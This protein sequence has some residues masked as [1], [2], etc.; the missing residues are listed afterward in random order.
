VTALSD[1]G[2]DSPQGDARRSETQKDHL[3]SIPDMFP[4]LETPH[5]AQA[6]ES[7]L[8]TKIEP[9]RRETI[10]FGQEQTPCG[11]CRQLRLQR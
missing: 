7:C 4:P 3:D 5:V 6:A 1:P 11:K 10:Q 8:E 2:S 9:R